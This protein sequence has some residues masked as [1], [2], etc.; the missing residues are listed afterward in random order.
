MGEIFKNLERKNIDIQRG[1]RDEPQKTIN[2]C[3][4][5]NFILS[6]LFPNFETKA[7]SHKK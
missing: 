1:G 3:D 7:K 5:L 4:K 2:F 6:F